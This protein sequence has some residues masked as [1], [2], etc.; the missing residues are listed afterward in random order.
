MSADLILSARGV[1]KQFGGLVA[2]SEFSLDVP[3]GQIVGLIGPNGAGKTTVFNLLVGLHKPTRGTVHLAGEEITGLKPHK[4]AARGMT[5]SFQNVALFPEM[6]VVDNV[7]TGALLNHDVTAAHELALALLRR[8]GLVDI[9]DRPARDLSFPERS[10][11]ELVRALCTEPTVLL[12]DEVMSVLSLSETQEVVDLVR[13][14]RDD[15]G[16]TFI[17]IEHHMKPIMSLCDRIIVLNFGRVIA[18]GAPRDVSRD[19]DV[20]EAYLGTQAVDEEGRRDA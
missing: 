6:T 1:T 13:S 14:L 7:L 17:V 3:R 15:D 12:L 4:I 20:L 16:L 8:V 9:A 19:P 11:V 18:D 10:R 5:K 2:V